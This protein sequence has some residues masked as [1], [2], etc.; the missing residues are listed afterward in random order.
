[1]PQY[2][3]FEYFLKN[4]GANNRF[5][6]THPSLPLAVSSGSA[7]TPPIGLP[8]PPFASSGTAGT[9]DKPYTAPCEAR[10]FSVELQ[11]EQMLGVCAG[12]LPNKFFSPH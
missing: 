6:E 1:M 7:L 8:W 5:G 4:Q 10:F 3:I 2:G 11:K 12:G 9:I